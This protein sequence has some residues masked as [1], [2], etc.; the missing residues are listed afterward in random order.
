[1]KDFSTE[2]TFKTSR[3]SGAG[4]QNVNKV[5][6]SVTVMWK[7]SASEFFSEEE[8][9]LISQQLKNRINLDGILQITVSDSRTQLQNR[10]I[11]VEGITELVNKSLIKPKPRKST[12]PSK[13]QIEKRLDTKKKL[14]AKKDNRRFRPDL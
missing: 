8:K 12:K 14:S 10:K 3:S 4:G 5:E 7:V 6:T 13:A 11:A 1:M 9:E 2:L